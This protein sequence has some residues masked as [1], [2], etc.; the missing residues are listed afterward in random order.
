MQYVKTPMLFMWVNAK[1]LSDESVRR[2]EELSVT[3]R[4]KHATDGSFVINDS[5]FRFTDNKIFKQGQRISFLLGWHDEAIPCGPFIIKSYTFRAGEDGKPNL[6]V[7]F[8]DLSHKM[9]KKAKKKKYTGTSVEIIKKIA[10]YH[11]IGYDI[12]SI[13]DLTFTD[14]YPLI[15]ANMS[16]AKLLQVLADKYGFAW[17]IEGNTLYFRRPQNADEVGRQGTVPVLSYR[18]NGA[19][20]LSF[21]ASVK[22]ISKGK[23]K[24]SSEEKDLVDV[25]KDGLGESA[26]S[27][28]GVVGSIVGEENVKMVRED[29]G[30]GIS[31]LKD[32]V[33]PKDKEQELSD[34]EVKEGSS[35]SIER[36]R[37]GL[38]E[39]V[40][41]LTADEQQL[42]N[43]I[44]NG[45]GTPTAEQQ[46]RKENLQRQREQVSVQ[47][48]QLRDEE[49]KA[50]RK[51]TVQTKNF[52]QDPG[53]F[54]TVTKV[55]EDGGKDD[56][57]SS[58]SN[59]DGTSDSSE[60]AK[61]KMA[62]K[63]SKKT[64]II[65]ATVVP[66]IASMLYRP[67]DS[68]IIAGVGER[69]SGKYRIS[70]VTHNYGGDPAFVTSLA[71]K[72]R[73]FRPSAK[74][75][76]NIAEKQD[77]VEADKVPGN[78]SSADGKPQ[79]PQTYTAKDFARDP[80]KYDT[81]VRKVDGNDV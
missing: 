75:K 25:L 55:V 23:K 43:D 31:S 52:L 64:E 15:Q 69:F 42:D 3:Y 60:E 26:E 80:G 22:Y 2:I 66:R 72:K 37:K 21:D 34:E 27:L 19:T 40:N 36:K 6:T 32:M 61:R 41:K 56:E 73:E 8:Q 12:E 13:A 28:L 78:Q 68:V 74:D 62:G 38:L 51:R 4:E 45:G 1:E 30:K 58:D 57:E 9:S 11:N 81:V 17:G 46:Q 39:A 76:A 44:L 24:G 14:D 59:S 10:E 20:L 54:K 71:V 29:I 18:I 5:D 65:E 79:G 77:P 53:L 7:S 47:Q 67:G 16:D 35:N 63:L 70:E 33:I 50:D 48:Q 49:K